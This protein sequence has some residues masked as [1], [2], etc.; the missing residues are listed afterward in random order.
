MIKVTVKLLDFGSWW[1][2]TIYWQIANNTEGK[3]IIGKRV[4]PLLKNSKSILEDEI[5]K[6]KMRIRAKSISE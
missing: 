3:T 2:K 4:I 6:K 1:I 5:T